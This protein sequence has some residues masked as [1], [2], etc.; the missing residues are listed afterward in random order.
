MDCRTNNQKMLATIILHYDSNH[1]SRSSSNC[2][3][4]MLDLV[5]DVPFETV[6]SF[7]HSFILSAR[8]GLQIEPEAML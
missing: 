1:R 6:H 7:I 2:G 3:K 4:P 8:I 5:L